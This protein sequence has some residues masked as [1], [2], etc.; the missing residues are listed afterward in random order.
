[1]VSDN[2]SWAQLL[3]HLLM[4]LLAA[5]PRQQGGLAFCLPAAVHKHHPSLTVWLVWR[6][7]LLFQVAPLTG[8][9]ARRSQGTTPPLPFLSST[10]SSPA[11]AGDRRRSRSPAMAP[12]P[13]LPQRHWCSNAWPQVGGLS[14]WGSVKCA[15]CLGQMTGLQGACLLHCPSLKRPQQIDSTPAVLPCRAGRGVWQR[16]DCGAGGQLRGAALL[17]QP[18]DK[19]QVSLI[20][21]AALLLL[22]L[23]LCYY[24]TVLAAS[25]IASGSSNAA[26]NSPM[27]WHPQQSLCFP[28]LGFTPPPPACPHPAPAPG[29]PAGASP[30]AP[31]TCGS[32]PRAWALMLCTQ[33]ASATAWSQTTSCACCRP[34]RVGGWVGGRAGGRAGGWA[35]GL[36]L[37]AAGGRE[38]SG[39]CRAPRVCR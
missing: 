37:S 7:L 9:C 34:S 26:S 23:P 12:A 20:P 28:F 30:G 19:V 10:C 15:G 24:C 2:E 25:G 5:A 18:G 36:V 35:G 27:I 38:R 4:L 39:W 13:P 29:A 11:A 22:P 3:L 21:A 32:S 17:P 33:T 6:P 31:T 16:H 14:G 8:V 1:M